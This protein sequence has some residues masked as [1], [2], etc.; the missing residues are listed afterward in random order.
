MTNLLHHNRRWV[1]FRE[2]INVMLADRRTY[3]LSSFTFNVGLHAFC[4]AQS[5]RMTVNTIV[6][7]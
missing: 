5:V 4:S 6:G 2:Q 1:S 3:A 7:L